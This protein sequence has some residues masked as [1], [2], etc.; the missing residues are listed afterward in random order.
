MI[1]GHD[2]IR[3]IDDLYLRHADN[4]DRLVTQYADGWNLCLNTVK[5]IMEDFFNVDVE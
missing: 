5:C 4:T 1:E 2:L 3:L